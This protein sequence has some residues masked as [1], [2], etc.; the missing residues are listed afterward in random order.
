MPKR[1]QARVA[2]CSSRRRRGPGFA[3]ALLWSLILLAS[4]VP[5]GEGSLRPA[6]SKGR[7]GPTIPSTLIEL[8]GSISSSPDGAE[9]GYQWRQLSGPDVTLSDPTAAKPYFRT[10][11]PGTYVF[12]LV[13]T[14]DDLA[15]E[16]HIVQLEIEAEN[17]PPVAKTP[18]EISGQVGKVLEVDGSDSFDPEGE[19]LFYR[20]R[21][22]SPGLELPSDEVTNP[23]LT[24]EP[25]EEGV[26]EVEL[27]VLTAS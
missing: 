3:F 11:E 19:E 24:F 27:V 21:S 4:A 12:E 20:W 10:S 18:R 22:L 1:L 16:P 8:D 2:P 6:S 5:A 23:V 17:L 7:S 13:V 26:Y 25:T 9:L 14:A 15:S